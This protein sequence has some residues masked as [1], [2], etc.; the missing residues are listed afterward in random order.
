MPYILIGY[1]QVVVILVAAKLLF[2]VPMVGSLALLSRDPG[3]L[4]RGEPRRRLHLLDARAQP[5]A[6]DAD[7]VLLLPA[8]DAAFGLHVPVPRHAGL[9]AGASGKSLPL[10][11]FLRIV[12]GILL[13]GN[14]WTDI[15]LEV[16]AL[17][18]FL[19]AAAAIALVRYRETLD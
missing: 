17:A 7:D 18:A 10:T 15:A 11:H 5:D 9:G 8:L 16:A 4:H 13:K 14:R 12:R 1:V 2:D 6:G 3:P 19:V